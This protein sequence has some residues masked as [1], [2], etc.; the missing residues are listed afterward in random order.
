MANNSFA[1]YCSAQNLIVFLDPLQPRFGQSKLGVK[2]GRLIEKISGTVSFALQGMCEA[3]YC[4]G[5]WR[6]RMVWMNLGVP[7]GHTLQLPHFEQ[8]EVRCVG[9]QRHCVDRV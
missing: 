3:K 4:W 2:V 5:G 8:L 6:R 1:I 7:L 9:A